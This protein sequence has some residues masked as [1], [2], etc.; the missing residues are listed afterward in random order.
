MKE[1]LLRYVGRIAINAGY[2]NARINELSDDEIDSVLPY[3][4][5]IKLCHLILS[6]CVGFFE[7]K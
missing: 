2:I 7:N 5:K 1:E 6:S 4:E 3:L